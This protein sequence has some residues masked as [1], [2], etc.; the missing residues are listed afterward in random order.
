MYSI[1]NGLEWPNKHA[2]GEEVMTSKVKIISTSQI[3]LKGAPGQNIDVDIEKV[4]PLEI[5]EVQ[6]I[7]PISAHI[8]ELNNIDPISVEFLRINEIKNLDPIKIEKFNVTSLPTVN[9]SLRQMPALDMNVRR[10]PPVSIGFHQNF[11]IPSNYTLR[12]KLFGIEFLRLNMKG[13]T[14]LVPK[15]RFRREQART[16]NQ[17]QPTTAVAGNP[18]IPSK[19]T[20]ESSSFRFPAQ[21]NSGHHS[22]SP[23]QMINTRQAL[24]IRLPEKN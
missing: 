19:C 11:H 8:K 10:L 18:A 1:I 20:E 7:A 14:T 21:C 4:A 6:K 15:E 22:G 16:R 17:S 24:N 5:A 23:N 3:G 13:E 12:A 2:T 9:V